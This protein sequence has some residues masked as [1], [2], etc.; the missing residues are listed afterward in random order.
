MADSIELYADSA[1]IQSRILST[2]PIRLEAFTSFLGTILQIRKDIRTI[3]RT[4]KA[5]MSPPREISMESRKEMAGK[6]KDSA[7]I[8]LEFSEGIES[9]F[10]KVNPLH[11][12]IYRLVLKKEIHYI[13]EEAEDIYHILLA[14]PA[15]NETYISKEEL[16]KRL[17]TS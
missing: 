14:R 16:L 3:N 8:I 5:M 17:E 13:R 1:L 6:L 2:L 9:F 11:R 15:D 10:S 4:F 12:F 7:Q